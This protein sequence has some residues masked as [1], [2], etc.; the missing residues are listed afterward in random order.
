MSPIQFQANQIEFS[1]S[2]Q[3]RQCPNFPHMQLLQLFVYSKTIRAHRR[4]ARRRVN[5]RLSIDLSAFTLSKADDHV[6]H[7]RCNTRSFHFIAA[8]VA[9][10]SYIFD[11]LFK[12]VECRGKYLFDVHDYPPESC[13]LCV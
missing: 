11:Q 7:Y 4:H 13:R 10:S 1:N 6:H 5:S 12:S 9:S 8:V 2:I 3:D